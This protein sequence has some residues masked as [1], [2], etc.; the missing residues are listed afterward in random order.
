MNIIGTPSMA[1]KTLTLA[2]YTYSKGDLAAC[3]NVFQ[4]GRKTHVELKTQRQAIVLDRLIH[5]GQ[6]APSVADIS[7]LVSTDTIALPHDIAD[8]LPRFHSPPQMQ[9]EMPM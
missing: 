2:W 4:V 6:A 5:N 8:H 9:R 3:V 1:T 7:F